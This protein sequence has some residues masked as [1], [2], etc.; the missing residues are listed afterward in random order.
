MSQRLGHWQLW[1]RP[2]MAATKLARVMRVLLLTS[3]VFGGGLV[4]I[5]TLSLVQ[6][7]ES[8]TSA[9][10]VMY[11]RFGE[12]KYPSTNITLQQFE[13]HI[14]MLTSGPYTVLP[15]LEIIEKIKK[16]ETLPARTVGITIDD[17]Y[18]STFTEAWPRLK[19]AKLPFT[20]FVSTNHVDRKLSNMM[21]WDQIRTLVK[22]GVTIGHHTA[23][24]LHMAEQKNERN[25]QD[26][27][28]SSERFQKEIGFVPKIFAYPYGEASQ[29]VIKIVRKSGFKAAFGQ[30]S[31]AFDKTS[32]LFYL[33][34]FAMNKTY[35]SPSRFRTAINALALPLAE[36]TPADPLI[37]SDNP[38]AIGFTIT[39]AIKRLKS[40]ACYASHAGRTNVIQLG[41]NR[42]EVRI[43]K[44]FPAGRTRLNCT[45]PAAEGRWHWFGWQYYVPKK[46]R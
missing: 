16:G 15:L 39:K 35:G 44:P 37:T 13:N 20:V 29:A 41:A 30:H 3:I 28:A 32:S 9:V 18:R 11:H 34:R 43:N 38:P 42:I 12:K 7:A 23:S 8:T 36:L 14:K 17:A 10:V 27:A 21:S 2:K 22:N 1:G 19:K 45:L 4:T 40:L 31:G 25:K 26:I 46:P 33:P 24:H 6:A 5:S